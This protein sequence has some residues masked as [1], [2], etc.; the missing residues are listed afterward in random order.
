MMVQRR[1]AGFV[2]VAPGRVLATFAAGLAASA[3]GIGQGLMTGLVVRDVL[4]GRPVSELT[5]RLVLIGV[6]VAARSVLVWLRDVA[7]H[8][9]A[10]KVKAHLR[11]ALYQQL[12]RLGPGYAATRGTGKVQATV[13][14]GVEALQ[15]YVGF[16]LPQVAIS[17]VSPLALAGYLVALD[18]VVGAIV[19]AACAL[20]PIAKPF[21]TK[22]L[23]R[24]GQRHWDAYEHLAARMLDALQGIS[25]LKLLNASGRRGRQLQEDS[26]AL[27][28]ATIANLR[29][30][31]GI[32]VVTATV[33][34]IGTA[35]AA[36]V[37]A[38][39]FAGGEL[40]A[41]ELLLVLF[42]AAECFRPLVEL[43]NYWHEGFYGMA[44]AGGIFD[45]LD[46]EPLVREPA[47]AVAAPTGTIAVELDEVTFTYPG[48]DRAALVALTATFQAG[49]T[50]AIVGRSGAGK[51]TV[52]SLLLRLFDPDAG[53][54]RAGGIDLRDLTI[55]DARALTSVVSQDI[56]LFHGTVRD[57]LLAARPTATAAELAHAARVAG[58]DELI[59]GLPLGW[60]TPVGERGA[61]LSGGERQRLAIARAV[62]RDAPVL[63]LDEATSSV[64]GEHEARIQSALAELGAGRTVIVIAHRLSTIAA[65][66]HVLVLE[67]GR[68]VEEGSGPQLLG[69]DGHYAQLVAAQRSA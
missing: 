12:L 59:A 53:V 54:V 15:A 33:F 38:L 32:Y 13:V 35:M 39:R 63:V 48:S 18:P 11:H 50:T 23:G 9:S 66:D 58:A 65:A 46:A 20:V 29:S 44:A 34:G 37:G 31:L 36:A 2:R 10:A 41:G 67:G 6:L 7:A 27:Y 1:L 61:S 47:Q 52:V 21:W 8:W 64:D 17:I 16:Y 60:E 43:Q 55:A 26:A 28:R 42:L 68:L 25:T 57:N 3:C 5:G 49:T 19:L 45:L 4:A 24:T 56:Y 51:S 14:D 69:R 22:L 30:S 62:L 40:T